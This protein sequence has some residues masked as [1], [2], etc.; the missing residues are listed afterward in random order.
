MSDLMTPADFIRETRSVCL[1]AIS[2][3][4]SVFKAPELGAWETSQ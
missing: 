2:F 3:G 4:H 1:F